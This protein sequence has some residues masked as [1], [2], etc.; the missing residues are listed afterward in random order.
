MIRKEYL[1]SLTLFVSQNNIRDVVENVVTCVVHELADNSQWADISSK[2]LHHFEHLVIFVMQ[3]FKRVHGSF[4]IGV[5]F[6]KIFINFLH[7]LV[8]F[9]LCWLLIFPFFRRRNC[10]R[11][12]QFFLLITFFVILPSFVKRIGF[13]L[14]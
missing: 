9:I 1:P 10:C 5:Q 8:V 14:G 13:F 3:F 6:H 4:K 2:S 12:L 11:S 7:F